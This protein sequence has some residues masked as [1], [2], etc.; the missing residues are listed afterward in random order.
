MQVLLPAALCCHQA[1]RQADAA[2][3]C[4]KSHPG[5]VCPMHRTKAAAG[6]NTPDCSA[7]PERDFLDLFVV[8]SS[9][10]VAPSVVELSVPLHSEAAFVSAQPV[11]ASVFQ[12]PPG[13]PPRA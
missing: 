6:D 2:D 4:G 1:S 13:P 5:Q 7:Q 12:I 8:L 3:C 9:G 10:V 11:T